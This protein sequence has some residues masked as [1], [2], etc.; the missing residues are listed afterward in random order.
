M[1]VS[2]IL[3]ARPSSGSALFSTRPLRSS[4][5][6]ARLAVASVI[7]TSLANAMT[8]LGPRRLRNPRMLIWVDVRPDL[9][10]F[11]HCFDLR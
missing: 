10:A 3:V 2:E 1:A 11:R 7:P 4:V 5:E 8:R 9:S 6:M